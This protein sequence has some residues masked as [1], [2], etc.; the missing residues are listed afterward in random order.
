MAFCR[1]T[2]IGVLLAGAVASPAFAADPVEPRKGLVLKGELD[3]P[4]VQK[5][6]VR[7]GAKDGSRLKV[8]LGF[9]G[10][11]KGGGLGELW[12]S[13]VAARPEVRV[14]DGRFDAELTGTTRSVGGVAGRTGH[15]TWTFSGRFT[16]REVAVATV[17]G[18]AEVRAGGKV[19]S[20]CEIRKPA[21]VRLTRSA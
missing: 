6:Q 11:C 13:N 7:T 20:R 21:S 17:R 8:S 2:V 14:R 12:A 15:F 10:T 18:T 19:V 5:M 4:R 16:D 3:F 1:F 9:H